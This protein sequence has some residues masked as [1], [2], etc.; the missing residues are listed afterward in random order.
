MLSTTYQ[1]L[2]SPFSFF[3]DVSGLCSSV[4]GT[5]S[6]TFASNYVAPVKQ[7][8]LIVCCMLNYNK[9]AVFSPERF[10]A[11]KFFYSRLKMATECHEMRGR[12]WSLTL[13]SSRCSWSLGADVLA[14]M[15]IKWSFWQWRHSC[16]QELKVSPQVAQVSELGSRSFS[17]DEQPITKSL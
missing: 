3:L 5:R 15:I 13:T 10:N 9:A 16:Q 2:D 8:P 17:V 12:V 14:K 7:T 1:V 6:R 11:E 4:Y